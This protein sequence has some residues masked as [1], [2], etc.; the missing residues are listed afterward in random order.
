MAISWLGLHW[1]GGREL[2]VLGMIAGGVA[3]TRALKSWVLVLLLGRRVPVFPLGPTLGFL[4][5]LALVSAAAGGAAW[6]AARL[7]A[8][9]LGVS[10]GN[11]VADLVQLAA[12]GVAAVCAGV[13]AA[14]LLR[15]REPLE[16]LHMV[17][18]ARSRR[19]PVAGAV[20]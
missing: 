11:R 14:A 3:L 6:G 18:R 15:F 2:L 9:A 8:D 12:G 16:L 20:E 1:W 13:A 4:I 5:R 7:G 19:R 10:A 17:Q